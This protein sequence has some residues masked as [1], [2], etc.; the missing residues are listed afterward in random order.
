MWGIHRPVPILQNVKS[1]KKVT[2]FV[3][4]D[5]TQWVLF[6]LHVQPENLKKNKT[7][8][9]VQIV[10]QVNTVKRRHQNALVAKPRKHLLLVH[11]HVCAKWDT[12]SLRGIGVHT[13]KWYVPNV[14]KVNI[15]MKLDRVLVCRALQANTQTLWVPPRANPV[16]LVNFQWALETLYVKIVH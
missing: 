14:R 4:Q 10:M 7:L 12:I 2:V 13:S 9:R 11:Q 1:V 3:S 15:P 8:S 16:P 5:I 6:V